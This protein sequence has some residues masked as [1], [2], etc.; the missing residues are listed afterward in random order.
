MAKLAIELRYELDGKCIQYNSV[1]LSEDQSVSHE[2]VR[3]ALSL[4][5]FEPPDIVKMLPG[6]PDGGH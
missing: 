6:L 3:Q 4:L 2:S 1:E 5:T